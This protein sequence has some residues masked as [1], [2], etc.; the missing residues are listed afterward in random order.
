MEKKLKKWY[1]E[2]IC[3]AINELNNS[4][5]IM[6]LLSVKY[7]RNGSIVIKF[8]MGGSENYTLNSVEY[9]IPKRDIPDTVEQLYKLVSEKYNDFQYQF[10]MSELRNRKRIAN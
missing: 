10:R 9:I 5:Q 1:S 8:L 4:S 6:H 3:G 2:K 7:P